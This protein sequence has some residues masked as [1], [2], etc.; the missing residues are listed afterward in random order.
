MLNEVLDREELKKLCRYFLESEFEYSSDQE[1]SD[2]RYLIHALALNTVMRIHAQKILREFAE[3]CKT[4][5]GIRHE[6]DKE[7]NSVSWEN[8]AELM[9]L[10]ELNEV[11]FLIK[12]YP[13]DQGLKRDLEKIMERKADVENN[14]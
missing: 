9:R 13:N 14:T 6:Y 12:L 5:N 2:L 11:E 3:K 4:L 7:L 8:R 1:L 10:R